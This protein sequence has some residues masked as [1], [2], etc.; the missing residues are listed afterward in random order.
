M[1][2]SDRGQDGSVYFARAFNFIYG[3][4]IGIA[5]IV[6]LYPIDYIKVRLYTDTGDAI[7]RRN[8]QFSHISDIIRETYR[9]DGIRGFYRGVFASMFAIFLYRS[10]YFGLYDA[11]RAVLPDD[12]KKKNLGSVYRRLGSYGYCWI[13]SVSNFNGKTSLDVNFW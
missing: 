2:L 7:S 13:R 3:T 11:T 4:L 1:K 5:G 8:H 6:C 10:V 9:S 12:I